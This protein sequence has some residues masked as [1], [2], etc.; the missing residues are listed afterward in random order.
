MNPNL[1][2]FSHAT[3]TGPSGA[4]AAATHAFFT[5]DYKPP[6]EQRY[7]EID[8]VKNQNG[9]FKYVYDNG[10]GFREWSPFS[11]VCEERFSTMGLGTAQQQYDNLRK[12]WNHPGL[13]G[14]QAPEGTYVVHWTPN[15]IE[16]NFR[17]FPVAAG[18]TSLEYEVIVQ[19][20]E[21]S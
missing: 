21:A 8:E 10:P 9:K 1:L 2:V 4:T 12:F 7:V 18:A 19:F 17:I 14:M 16:K 3:Y 11:V 15:S 13:L 5:K 6:A 20:E